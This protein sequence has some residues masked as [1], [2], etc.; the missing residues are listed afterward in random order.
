MS[1]IDEIKAGACPRFDDF[2]D[3]WGPK[4]ELLLRLSSTPQDPIWHAE[5]DVHVHTTMVLDELYALIEDHDLSAE[6]RLQLVLGAVFHDIAKPITTR[7]AEK[8]GKVR[9]IAPRHADKGR[10]YLAYRLR[11]LDLAWSTIDAVLALVGHHHDPKQLVVKDGTKAQYRRLASMCDVELV[12]LLELA[13]NRGRTCDDKAEQLEYIE[14]FKA[15]CD[16]FEVGPDPFSSA[17]AVVEDALSDAPDL[18]R[19]FV[20]G[21]CIRG[22]N[23][24]RIQMA[25]EEIA[26]SYSYRDA[27]SHV[28]IL[29]GPSGCGKSTWVQDTMPDYNIVSLDAL[30]EDIA[31]HVA[32]QSKNGQVLQAAKEQLKVHLRAKQPVVWDATNLRRDFRSV[33]IKLAY[34]YNAFAELVVFQPTPQE[35]LSANAQRDRKVPAS[36]IS[37][38]FA[39]AEFPYGDEAHRLRFVR[40]T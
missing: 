11:E 17:R 8:D 32:D 4:F 31:G 40:E 27:F 22:L 34:D 29:C 16:E 14:L 7:E 18:T 30:R 6:R 10:S 35:C 9:I 20:L 21:E 13:D 15:Y 3:A 1:L 2:V 38:Q 26:R 33:P 37:K 39:N 19:Q 12:Y 25:E 28:V 23:S 36:A 24:G 5:G